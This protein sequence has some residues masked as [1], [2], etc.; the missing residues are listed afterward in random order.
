M[1]CRVF[2]GQVVRLE[3]I[4]DH[5]DK[6]VR[7]R[8]TRIDN[9][10]LNLF[11]FDYDLTFMVFFLNADGKVYARYGGR[12]SRDADNRQSLKGLAYT[13]QSVLAMHGRPAPVFAPRLEAAPG[14]LRDGRPETRPVHALPPGQG[15]P[16]REPEEGGPVDARDLAWRYPLPENLGLTLEVD[17]GNVVKQVKAGSSAAAAGLRPGDRLT[18]LGARA[19]ALLRRRSVRPRSRPADGN[20]GHRLAARARHCTSRRSSCPPA[21]ARPTSAGGRL[22]SA[23]YRRCASTA[24]TSAP[25]NRKTLGLSPTQLAFRQQDGLPRQ[26]R[27]AGIQPGD[28]IVGLDGRTP[29]LDVTKLIHYV[30]RNYLVG[31]T[32]TI[33]LLRNGKRL[34]LKMPLLP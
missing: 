19:H 27:A 10:D 7:V 30:Q 23:S 16:E 21:G 11:E 6:Y 13:M 20:P 34:S 25:H 2:D 1:D 5:A 9:A 32:V 31:D 3:G 22:C 12:D 24:T 29:D 28:I 17:R 15:K 26:A 4:K 14:H 8:L 18:R 33:Q